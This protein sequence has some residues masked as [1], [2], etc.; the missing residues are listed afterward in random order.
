MVTKYKNFINGQ[1]CLFWWAQQ[2]NINIYVYLM[3]RIKQNLYIKGIL[4]VNSY[5]SDIWLSQF[6]H[7]I[8][9]CEIWT[10]NYEL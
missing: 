6:W 3:T 7:F 5:S 1:N 10:R 4:K 9:N 8:Q 2:I